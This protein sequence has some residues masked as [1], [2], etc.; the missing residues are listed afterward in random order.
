[1]TLQINTSK[2]AAMDWHHAAIDYTFDRWQRCILFWDVMRQRGN[3]YL[4]HLRAGQPPVLVFDYETILN[5]WDFDP[6]VN[7]ALV[8]ICDRRGSEDDRR[9]PARQSAG[10]RR[11]AASDGRR[12]DTVFP[13]C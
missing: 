3:N 7:Y 13:I 12:P 8:K 11:T 6:P 2:A 1:M 9:Q 10:R 5:G 4:D